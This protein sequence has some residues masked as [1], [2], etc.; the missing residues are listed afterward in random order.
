M[1]APSGVEAARWQVEARGGGHRTKDE[2]KELHRVYMSGSAV[3]GPRGAARRAAWGAG[4]NRQ[5]AAGGS[6]SLPKR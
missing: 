4:G 3:V 2:A 6:Q 5:Q 1:A